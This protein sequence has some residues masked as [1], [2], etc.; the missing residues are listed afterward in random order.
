MGDAG[1][2]RFVAAHVR[3]VAR[4]TDAD[5]NGLTSL[6]LRWAWPGGHA[7][8]FDPVAVDWL[9]RWT[10]YSAATTPPECSCIEGRCTVCN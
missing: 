5:T 10:P 6:M 9:R 4:Q 1:N 3:D 2:P 8:R 7:D